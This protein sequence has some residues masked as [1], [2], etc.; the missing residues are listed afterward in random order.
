ML[1]YFQA[2][3]SNPDYI[4]PGRQVTVFLFLFNLAQW[5]VFTFEI[6]KVRA[7]RVEEGKF[8]KSP[9]LTRFFTNMIST[10]AMW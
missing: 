1:F 3:M 6:Q 10:N 9:P 2:Y 5:I 8:C 4:M 7:S